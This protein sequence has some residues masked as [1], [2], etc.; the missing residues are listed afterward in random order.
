[1][2]D[3]SDQTEDLTPQNKHIWEP[4]PKF[5]G[6][7]RCTHCGCMGYRGIVTADGDG[8]PGSHQTAWQSKT[9]QRAFSIFPYICK[10]QGCKAPA[11]GYGRYQF[12]AA[13]QRA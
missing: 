5:S 7:Y 8:T 6:R 2:S 13:H 12:C 1:M 3:N 10:S 4:I 11:K 9:A